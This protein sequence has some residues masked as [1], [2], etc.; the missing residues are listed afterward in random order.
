M[1][2]A[3]QNVF[4]RGSACD[5]KIRFLLFERSQNVNTFPFLLTSSFLR[6][7]LL[8]ISVAATKGGGNFFVVENCT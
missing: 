8:H 1:A 3:Y 7:V 6:C 5:T 4:Q 2:L